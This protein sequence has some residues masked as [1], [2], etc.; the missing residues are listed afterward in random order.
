MQPPRRRRHTL[1]A[2]SLIAVVAG[3]AGLSFAAVPLY[4]LFCQVTGYGGTT[5]A[6]KAAPGKVGERVITVQFNADV[7]PA[8][9]WRFRPAQRQ[10]SI[11]V[12]ER[13]L[14]YYRADNLSDKPIT[15]V[16]T[17]NVT[18]YKAGVYFN[19]I[20]CFCFTE[21]HLGAGES[22]AMPV[23]FFIEPKIVN[24]RNRDDVNTITLSYTLFPAKGTSGGKTSRGRARDPAK[25]VEIV[26]GRRV[27][28]N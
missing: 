24:D 13:A 9:P 1:V 16:A 25:G 18:P 11:A 2:V 27:P 5:Q 22:A 15:G 7:S 8:L 28:V 6:A 17:F 12:G 19:K 4:R 14:A 26:D 3:M 23:S 20:E 21:Q 10:V